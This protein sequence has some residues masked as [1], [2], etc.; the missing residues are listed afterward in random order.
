MDDA[1]F[2]GGD[3]LK[4]AAEYT[5]RGADTLLLFDLSETEED[6][7]RSLSLIKQMTQVTDLPLYGLGHVN[8]TED[9]KKLLYAGCQKVFLNGS[10]ESNVE[11]LEE[12]SKRFGRERIGLSLD[13]L[14]RKFD[15][16]TAD[17]QRMSE[18][19]Y[20]IEELLSSEQTRTLAG[21]IL[22]LISAPDL[23]P[24]LEPLDLPIADTAPCTGWILNFLGMEC[25]TEKLKELFGRTKGVGIADERTR[26]VGVDLV[27][28]KE[29]ILADG[30]PIK[31]YES[32]FSWNDF[33]LNSDGLIP[34]I[35]QEYQTGEVLMLAYMNEEAYEETVKT[36]HMTYF[37]RSRK[38]LWVKGLSS[39]HFQYV[40]E[41][42]PDC[43][44]D[45]ILAKVFQV[46]AACHTGNRS[47]FYRTM[48]QKE[49]AQREPEN[50]LEE[51]Y[52]VIMD[53]KAHPKEG[54]Y[55]NY[56]FEKGIDK[57]LKKVGEESAEVIIAAKNPNPEE[58]LYEISDLLYHLM[59]LMV[60]KGITWEEI[61]QELARR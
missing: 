28:V 38:E 56:L 25:T 52:G 7:E 22:L 40:K 8:R 61:K 26:R 19:D 5:I 12:V 53:R 58:S 50:I 14:F 41:M 16:D 47:C 34:V 36:G 57:I 18:Y 29:E 55:T 3:A 20:R 11:M 21:E 32:S 59:V 48:W 54:S 30:I 42:R 49:D 1:P 51:V 15:K 24:D 44:N 46:G 33:K 39:G 43:D 27:A 2:A 35:V 17:R 4:L 9:V 23:A 60:E 13:Y 45:T 31:H 37:S 6:H 10:K